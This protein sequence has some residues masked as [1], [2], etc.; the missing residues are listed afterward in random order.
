[1]A[2]KARPENALKTRRSLEL[3]NMYPNISAFLNGNLE[4]LYLANY[5]LKSVRLAYLYEKF[6][7][8][9]EAAVLF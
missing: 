7:L 3:V 5:I 4:P 9:G 8:E 1:M 6:Q 2:I